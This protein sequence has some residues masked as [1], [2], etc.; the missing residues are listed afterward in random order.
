[1]SGTTELIGLATLLQAGDGII[2]RGTRMEVFNQIYWVFLIL[3]TI[4]G[5][6]VIGYMLYNAYKYRV[7]SDEGADVDRPTLGEL[8]RGGGGGRKLFLSFGLSA[9][10][11]ISLIAWTY[12][13]LLFVEGAAADQEAVVGDEDPIVVEVE[14]WRFGWD[15]TYEEVPGH[16]DGVVVQ[17]F[18]TE[19]EEVFEDDAMV[20]P[21]DRTIHL[22]VTGQEGDVWHT[23][24][25]P[26]LRVKADAI[27]GQYTEHWFAAEE[28]DEGQYVA[29]CFELC[30]NGH[31][32]MHAGVEVV[33]EEE[34]DEWY[35]EQYEEQFEDE[36]ENEADDD[37]DAAVDAHTPA[38]DPNLM[39]VPA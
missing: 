2:P 15:F 17:A 19:E 11:V 4:V 3:G 24:G 26:E 29:R 16:E 39:E 35:E 25:V 5:V 37:G 28:E 36:D 13:T 38:V 8:P 6:V 7:G 22:R 27:P 32:A 9:I 20:V 12:G 10:I 23:F 14:G 34:F 33:P 31:S 21:S 30:G 1:M 18:G